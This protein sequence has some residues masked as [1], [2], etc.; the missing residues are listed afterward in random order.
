MLLQKGAGLANF[1]QNLFFLR[2]FILAQHFFRPNFGFLN[3][4]QSRP[5]AKALR[6]KTHH[7]GDWASSISETC[8]KQHAWRPHEFDAVLK[9]E[10]RKLTRMRKLLVFSALCALIFWLEHIRRA[11]GL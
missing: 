9:D 1:F 10:G 4:S 2:P 5:L 7:V 8:A 6:S 11:R 3:H